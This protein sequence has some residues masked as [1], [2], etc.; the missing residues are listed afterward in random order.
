VAVVAVVVRGVQGLML[1]AVLAVTV[2]LVAVAQ[3]TQCLDSIPELVARVLLGRAI[4]EGRQ[5]TTTL[6][7]EK[8]AAAVVLVA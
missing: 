8:A 7:T 5:V 1:L 3:L 4:M 2:G 6:P